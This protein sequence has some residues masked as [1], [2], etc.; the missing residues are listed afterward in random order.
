IACLLQRGD[1]ALIFTPPSAQRNESADAPLVPKS[2]LGILIRTTSK[3][4]FAFQLD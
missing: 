4:E 3:L 2:E 1:F